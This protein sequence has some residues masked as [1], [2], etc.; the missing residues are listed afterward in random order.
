MMAGRVPWIVGVLVVVSVASGVVGAQSGGS[1]LD[2]VFLS[3]QAD[4]G[5][6]T[7]DRSCLSCHDTTEFSGG[8]FR[9]S[10]VGRT[11]GD[12]FDTISTLMPEEDPGSLSPAEYASL[13]AFLLRLNGYPSGETALQ[14]DLRSLQQLPIVEAPR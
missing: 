5:E 12:L 8:R 6:R 2:G 4:R 10:W 7:F 11:A 1:V 9:L 3:A 14:T 13:V